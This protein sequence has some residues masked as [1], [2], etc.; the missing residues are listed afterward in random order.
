MSTVG[1]EQNLIN[2]QQDMRCTSLSSSTLRHRDLKEIREILGGYPSIL[3]VRLPRSRDERPDNCR[4]DSIPLWKNHI[5]A[6]L[7]LPPPPFILEVSR[8][9]GIPFFQ[10]SPGAMR[11]ALAFHIVCHVNG[12]QNTARLFFKTQVLRK[13][14][15]HYHFNSNPKHKIEFL[16]GL[17]SRDKGW[18]GKYFFVTIKE[19]GWRSLVGDS[20]I[21]WHPY[22]HTP[23]SP[24]SLPRHNEFAVFHGLN[25]RHDSGKLDCKAMIESATVLAGSALFSVYP[26][27]KI[28]MSWKLN[29]GA[30]V[31]AL[32][33]SFASPIGIASSGVVPSSHQI[34][35]IS[36]SPAF[37][38]GPLRGKSSARGT[39]TSRSLC[40]I[41]DVS[42]SSD[43]NEP[44]TRQPRRKSTA[45]KNDGATS[46]VGKKR[47]RKHA[48]LSEESRVAVDHLSSPLVS[49]TPASLV[50]PHQ[51][52]LPSTLPRSLQDLRGTEFQE[53]LM[54]HVVPSDLETINTMNSKSFNKEFCQAV[55]WMSLRILSS[56]QRSDALEEK[57]QSKDQ[58]VARA[59]AKSDALEAKLEEVNSALKLLNAEKASLC[60]ELD[61][62]RKS[63]DEE[64]AR[65]EAGLHESYQVQ[66]TKAKEEA[67]IYGTRDCRLQYFLT[68]VG[69]QFLK[70]MYEDTLKAF[71]KTPESLF[72]LG[73]AMGVLIKDVS[74]LVMNQIGASDD[75]RALYNFD[76]VVRDVDSKALEKCLGIDSQ[77]PAGPLWWAPVADKALQLFIA[78]VCSD[79]VPSSPF[80]RTPYLD[81][82]RANAEPIMT[83][84]D[85]DNP[86]YAPASPAPVAAISAMRS[87]I[88]QYHSNVVTYVRESQ[89]RAEPGPIIAGDSRSTAPSDQDEV[90]DGEVE[91]DAPP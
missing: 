44:P 47:L 56:I 89:A 87:S 10:I 50:I 21:K 57:L 19:G 24:R 46:S 7:R 52:S 77:A 90:L 49:L 75:Q 26:R 36:Q 11:R 62:M 20:E 60:S 33:G 73:P 64:I 51:F 67:Y 76:H 12:I 8:L 72:V 63:R 86:F 82:A 16:S 18:L 42:A 25:K 39:P 3:E 85:R 79:P 65:A 27:D 59:V 69:H 38:S 9:F 88:E 58:E 29:S 14:G 91:A 28:G 71:S 74:S 34:D 41:D 61:R 54:A 45:K 78:G 40:L 48:G 68:G 13:T 83:R 15:I 32:T 6:G 70:I 4:E 23:P 55:E 1:A 2:R 22:K 84:V 66:L 53:R 17:G 43:E 5:D 37:D 30:I 35:P 81:A 31:P 80:I